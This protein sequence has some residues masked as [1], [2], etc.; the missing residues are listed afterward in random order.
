M[1]VLRGQCPQFLLEAALSAVP[2]GWAGGGRW[3]CVSHPACLGLCSPRYNGS[4]RH[5]APALPC[6]AAKCPLSEPL[7][8]SLEE[9]LVPMCSTR[10]A[11]LRWSR[12]APRMLPEGSTALRSLHLQPGAQPGG[13][14]AGLGCLWLGSW[15]LC[16]VQRRPPYSLLSSGPAASTGP[17]R[18]LCS[19][20]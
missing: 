14:A 18:W 5:F 11:S 6:D 13:R 17:I 10:V 20:G 2:G 4:E 8:A 19:P 1:M 15:V 3:L 16:P 12:R 7:Q 9:L